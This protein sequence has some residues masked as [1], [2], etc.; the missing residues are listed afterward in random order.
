MRED[1]YINDVENE[2]IVLS[3]VI[4]YDKKID[5]ISEFHSRLKKVLNS[6]EERSETIYVSGR[7]RKPLDVGVNRSRGIALI[8]IDA[9]LPHPPE[10]IPTMMQ[11]WREGYDIVNMQKIEKHKDTLLRR[12]FG[13]TSCYSPNVFSKSSLSESLDN[14]CLIGRQVIG[15]LEER[16]G[17]DCNTKALIG[18][19]SFKGTTMKFRCFQKRA[20]LSKLTRKFKSVGRVIFDYFPFTIG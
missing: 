2:N 4:S 18:L 12:P 6:L 11:K 14:F 5:R 15:H 13:S 19:T 9:G 10:L 3:I 8:F 1:S 17:P 20:A 7:S 16:Q